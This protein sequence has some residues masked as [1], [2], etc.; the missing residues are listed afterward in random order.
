M[1]RDVRPAGVVPVVVAGA[2]GLTVCDLLFH[3]RTD[4]LGYETETW[5]GQAWWVP[6]TFAAGT[7][8]FYVSAWTFALRLPPAPRGTLAGAIAWFVAAYAVTGAFHRHPWPLLAGLVVAF[9]CRLAFLPRPGVV[10]AYAVLL[11]VSGCLG[12]GLLSALGLFAYSD[13]DVLNVPVWLFGLYLH[14]APMALALASRFGA[15]TT[16]GLR[17]AQRR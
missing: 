3:V 10:A 17:T 2:L 11:G 4:T 12:E 16:S 5:F 6:L 1:P 9:L 15:S 7:L 13:K 8:W 14:G